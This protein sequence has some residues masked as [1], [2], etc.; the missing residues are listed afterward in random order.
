LLVAMCFDLSRHL[1]VVP[2]PI[3]DVERK[4]NFW[5]YYHSI[6]GVGLIFTIIQFS[7]YGFALF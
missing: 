4:A 6:L 1:D 2:Q 3:K 5:F 7:M